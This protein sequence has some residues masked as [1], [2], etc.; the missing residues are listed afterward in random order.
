MHFSALHASFS[1]GAIFLKFHAGVVS[2]GVSNEAHIEIL[3]MMSRRHHKIPTTRFHGVCW[4]V[5][6]PSSRASRSNLELTSLTIRFS[7][8]TE[9]HGDSVAA[10]TPSALSLLPSSHAS[11]VSNTLLRALFL[12]PFVLALALDMK[13][14]FEIKTE[15][16]TQ[17][18]IIISVVAFSS[19]SL[20]TIAVFR[21]PLGLRSLRDRSGP[22]CL[23]G[24]SFCS[25]LTTCLRCLPTL[26]KT[27][28]PPCPSWPAAAT[29]TETSLTS[30]KSPRLT[31]CRRNKMN[32]I[33][34]LSRTSTSAILPRRGP[35][36][37][38]MATLSLPRLS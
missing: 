2:R 4:S 18:S 23:R 6:D 27:N 12:L 19:G 7:P 21:Q 25:S 31:L 3:A 11:A 9:H 24:P 26:L 36:S 22:Y 15:P 33:M 16:M 8:F 10:I 30:Y 5:L 17:A 14:V 29:P 32:F 35:S 28:V 34:T 13:F 1:P 38:T 20:A 37:F